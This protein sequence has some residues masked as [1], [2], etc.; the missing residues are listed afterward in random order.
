MQISHHSLVFIS[1]DC[2]SL[3]G[4]RECKHGKHCHLTGKCLGRGDTNLWSHVDVTTGVGGTWNTRT[5]GIAYSVDKRSI[6]LGQLD[7][8][9]CVGSLT[10]LGYGNHHVVLVDDGIAVAE[11]RC[12][13]HLHGYSAKALDNLFADESGVPRCSACHNHASLGV[14]QLLLIVD[15]CTQHHVIHIHVDASTHTVGDTIRLL[16][17]LL[18]HKVG[19]SAFLYLS[20]RKSTRLNS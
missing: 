2:A 7:G 17:N 13:F 8:G 11:L 12:I 10:R 15:H 6:L 19:I 4:K 9:K 5:D 1:A 18:K 16:E 20:D 3:V 14:E